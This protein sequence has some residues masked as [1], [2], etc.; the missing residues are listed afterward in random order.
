MGITEIVFCMSTYFPF[1]GLNELRKTIVYCLHI[2]SAKSTVLNQVS[3]TDG[4]FPEVSM[5]RSSS[6]MSPSVPTASLV[7]FR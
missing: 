4:L 5:L 3:V 6:L 2:T 1:S 7:C